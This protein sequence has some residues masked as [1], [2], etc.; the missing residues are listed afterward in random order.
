MN[1]KQLLKG[2]LTRKELE[3]AR[4]SF[5]IIGTIAVLEVPKELSKK[6]KI[7]AEA[8]LGTHRNIKTVVKK[9]GRHKGLFRLQKTRHLAGEKTKETVHRENKALVKLNIDKVYFSPRLATERMRIAKQARKGEEILVMFSGCAPYALVI[10]KNSPV[11]RVTAVEINPTAHK[12][13]EENLKLNNLSNIRLIMGDVK[14]IVPKLRHKFDRII[15]PLPKGAE[16]YL[17]SAITSAKRKG[18]IH[19]Y[20]FL[21]EKDIP[22]KAVARISKACKRLNKECEIVSVTKCGQLAARKYRVCVDFQIFS[23]TK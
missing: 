15:M 21:D 11:K 20:D 23:T 19:Y 7:M 16:K 10:A 8:I 5:D 4:R 9:E 22:S 12:Y 14:T 17:P 2:K 3:A 18:T 13:A 1:L 6:A